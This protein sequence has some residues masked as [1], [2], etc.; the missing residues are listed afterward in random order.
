L[1]PED[2]TLEARMRHCGANWSSSAGGIYLAASIAELFVPVLCEHLRED[3]LLQ[4]CGRSNR[5]RVS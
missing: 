2:N 5:P 1:L 3:P 4:R